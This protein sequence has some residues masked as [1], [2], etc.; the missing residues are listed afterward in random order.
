MRTHKRANFDKLIAME[1]D[2][3]SDLKKMPVLKL[4][5]HT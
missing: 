2:S 4:K 1:W 3:P 5:R